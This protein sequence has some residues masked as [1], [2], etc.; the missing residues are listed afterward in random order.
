MEV[1]RV[2]GFKSGNFVEVMRVRGLRVG[3]LWRW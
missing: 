3:I 1:M 2:R